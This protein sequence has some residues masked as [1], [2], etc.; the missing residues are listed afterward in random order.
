VLAANGSAARAQRSGAEA[1]V[2]KADLA[3]APLARWLG[4]A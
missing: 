2:P 3:R 1:F 4:A